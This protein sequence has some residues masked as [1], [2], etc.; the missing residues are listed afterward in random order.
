MHPSALLPQLLAQS[1][2]PRYAHSALPDAPVRAERARRARWARAAASIRR[3]SATL[4]R[5]RA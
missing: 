3:R 2:L 1:T 4:A 5:W